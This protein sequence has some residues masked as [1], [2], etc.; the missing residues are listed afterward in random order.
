MI[1][2]I[3][4]QKVAEARAAEQPRH[5]QTAP[6]RKPLGL[7][8]K[9]A[10]IFPLERSVTIPLYIHQKTFALPPVKPGDKPAILEITDQEER[11][12]AGNGKNGARI[13]PSIDTAMALVDYGSGFTI[14]RTNGGQPGLWVVGTLGDGTLTFEQE[15][16]IMRNKQALFFQEW[17]D[18]GRELA[19]AEAWANIQPIHRLAASYLGLSGEVWM[20]RDYKKNLEPCRHCREFISAEASKCPKCGGIHNVQRYTA[21]V[22]EEQEAVE[23]ARRKPVRVP[24]PAEATV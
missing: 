4:S 12:Y 19:A 1:D 2:A 9:V 14:G 22:A 15:T 8:W 18:N 17:V 20:T 11:I 6:P 13:V 24:Q 5:S 7:K 16:E 3:V 23:R 21:L 10:S